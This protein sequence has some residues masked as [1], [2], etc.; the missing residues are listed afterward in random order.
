MHTC[1]CAYIFVDVYVYAYV[2]GLCAIGNNWM[3]KSK[4]KLV[5]KLR[6]MNSVIN[7]ILFVFIVTSSYTLSSLHFPLL[8]SL[9]SSPPLHPIPPKN[10]G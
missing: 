3:G 1:M 4:S 10:V 2:G 5:D 8:L 6:C 9:S 7:I